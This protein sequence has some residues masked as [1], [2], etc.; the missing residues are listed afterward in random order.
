M[1]VGARQN[2]QF[3]RQIT[4]FLGNDRALS[5]FKLRIL[6]YLISVI[7]LQKNFTKLCFTIF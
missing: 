7:K 1:V 3:S 6:H 2:F 4:W 5:K